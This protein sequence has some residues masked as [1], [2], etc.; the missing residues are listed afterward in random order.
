MNLCATFGLTVKPV[1]RQG[2]AAFRQTPSQRG[3]RMSGQPREGRPVTGE[4]ETI[5]VVVVT[6]NS[7]SLIEDLVASLAPGLRGLSWHL[8]VADN[9]S[10][11][12][13]VE[14][15]RRFA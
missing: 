10:H 6:Y 11:D 8:T 5:A 9:D 1:S 7:A 3:W 2:P 15:V 14:T 13:T 4:P 12:G